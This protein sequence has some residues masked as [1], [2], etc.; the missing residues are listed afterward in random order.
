MITGDTIYSDSLIQHAMGADL[1]VSDSLNHK[2]SQTVSDASKDVES[3]V[4]SVTEDIQ[5]SHI[6]PEEAARVAKESGVRKLLITH[7][8]PPVPDLLIN[9]FLRDARAVFPGEVRM[10]N[11]GT[12]AKLPVNSDEIIITELLR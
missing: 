3:N 5:E 6:R 8:L 4:S 9:P 2:M 1:M 7:V 12:M 10:A 11:D